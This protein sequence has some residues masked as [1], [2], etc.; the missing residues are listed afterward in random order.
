[1]LPVAIVFFQHNS[2]MP[3]YLVRALRFSESAYGLLFTINTAL[4]ILLEIPLTS[5]I[6][7]W[8]YA[9]TMSLGSLGFGVG[10]G[11]LAHFGPGV[12][13]ATMFFMGALSALMFARI[14][15]KT[16]A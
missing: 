3:I 8:S 10:F 5:A 6:V 7:H 2:T 13:W 16:P 15:Q 12:L 1:M 14:P 4:I 9:R 11:A